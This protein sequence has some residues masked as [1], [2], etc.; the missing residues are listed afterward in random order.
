[1]NNYHVVHKD[2][3]WRLEREGSPR[4]VRLFD[5][6]EEAVKSAPDL[7]QGPASVKIHLKDGSIQ[8]ERTYP[9]SAD[10][11]NSPG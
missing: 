9:R 8:E 6:K 11:S 4:A 3:Q 5:T 10:P 1:M 2:D 7:V